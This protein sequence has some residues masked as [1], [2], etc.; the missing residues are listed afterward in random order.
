MRRACLTSVLAAVALAGC[1][2]KA[3]HAVPWLPSPAAIAAAQHQCEDWATTQA[4]IT[5]FAQGVGALPA[6]PPFYTKANFTA[7]MLAA[8]DG[9]VDSYTR[10]LM[11]YGPPVSM[12]FPTG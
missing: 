9:Q 5:G 7:C 1:G 2:G 12:G 10:Y 3:P 11:K 6:D 4:S 8:V